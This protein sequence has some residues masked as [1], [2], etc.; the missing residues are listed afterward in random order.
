MPEDWNYIT[1]GL[2]KICRE[3]TESSES[4]LK[5]L[6]WAEY[7]VRNRLRDSKGKIM[8]MEHVIYETPLAPGH[9]PS[10]QKPGYG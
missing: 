2:A 9:G 5:K 7:M 10:I 4:A 3:G 6:A 8:N 1:R